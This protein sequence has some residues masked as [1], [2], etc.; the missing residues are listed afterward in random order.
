MVVSIIIPTY[1]RCALLIQTLE[2]FIAQDYPKNNFEII[3]CDNNSNDGT[4]IAVNDFI[5]FHPD[6]NIR[7]FREDRQGVHYA[8]NSAAKLAVGE[9]LYF[10]DDDMLADRNLI[11]ELLEI[12][13]LD[14]TIASATGRILPKWEVQP[15][16]WVVQLCSN[17]LLSLNN[18]PE[19]LIISEED[20]NVFSCHQMIKCDVFFQSGG[21]NPENVMG[22]WI[23]DGET[24]L[25][26]KIR[27]LKYKFGFWGKSVI[28]HQIP[29]SRM[30]Q[31]YL[32]KRMSNQGNSDS[33]SDYRKYKP[34]L[35]ALLIEIVKFVAK[36]IYSS[37]K[38]IANLVRQNINWR[39]NVAFL[40]YYFARIKY[41]I[42]LIFSRNHRE[43][44]LKNNWLKD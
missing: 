5:K 13:K 21:F 12:F 4:S 39:M 19:E 40:N 43:F 2:S 42:D 35:I 25:N 14:N 34:G 30:T 24:G 20:C 44:I 9:F 41:N 8:R 17:A 27:E 7:Y 33:Y 38:F 28:Y 36:G 29:S 11:R 1:N 23:G 37:L 3:I 16:E 26:I 22:H 32:N 10:T 6:Y 18:P 31:K 15:P